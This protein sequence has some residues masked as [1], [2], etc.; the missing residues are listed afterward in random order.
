MPQL[1]KVT[2]LSQFFWLCFFYLGF[3]YTLLKYFLP[4][5]SRVLTLRKRKMSLSQEGIELLYNENEGLRKKSQ[6]V[7]SK[8]FTLS[9][10]LFHNFFS[11]ATK[12]VEKTANFVNKTHYQTINKSYIELLGESS[13]SQNILLYHASQKAPEKVALKSLIENLKNFSLTK[14]NNIEIIEQKKIKKSVK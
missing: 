5:I 1:D 12:W 9:K 7:L 8:G 4:K 14:A 11:N 2:F 10:M 3:Y 6:D 13:L